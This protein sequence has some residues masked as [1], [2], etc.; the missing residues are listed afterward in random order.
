MA[1]RVSKKKHVL[2]ALAGTNWG[3]QKET[4]LMTY[5]SLGRS[6]VN[7][8]RIQR[9]QNEVFRIITGSHKMSS[10]DHLHSET[11]M[12][13]VEDHLNFLSAQYLVHCLGT[14]NVCH[15]I[16]NM[17]H[18]PKEMKGTIFTRHNKTVLPLLANNRKHTPGNSHLI[19]Q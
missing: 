14:E 2:K 3:Q 11:E 9:A 8:A 6:I 7:Y 18:P 16:T 4:L 1:N 5:Q 19:C 10:I 12:L 17:D 15:H 13:Q